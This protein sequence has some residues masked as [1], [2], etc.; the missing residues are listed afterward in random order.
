MTRSGTVDRI[1]IGVKG[2]VDHAVLN[3]SGAR[4]RCLSTE[5]QYVHSFG[6]IT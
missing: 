5:W 2:L 6:E 3:I 1:C 4:V